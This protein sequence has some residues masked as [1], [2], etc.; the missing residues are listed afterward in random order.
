M[1]K[2]LENTDSAHRKREIFWDNGRETKRWTAR[3]S[4]MTRNTTKAHQQ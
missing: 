3:E 2:I 4:S 1:I